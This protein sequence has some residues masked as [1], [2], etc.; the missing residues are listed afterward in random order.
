MKFDEFD[1]VGK[2]TFAVADL[3]KK[4]NPMK[5]LKNVFFPT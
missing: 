2:W 1:E 3:N 5:Y 4:A